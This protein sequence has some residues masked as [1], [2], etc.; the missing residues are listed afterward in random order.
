[1]P[2]VTKSE[3]RDLIYKGLAGMLVTHGFRLNRRQEGFVRRIPDGT[4]CIGVALAD[5]NP[6]YV[7]SL[8]L[9][10]RLESVQS[11]LN[12][13]SGSPQRYHASTVTAITQLEYF[14]KKPRTE[15]AVRTAAD[16]SNAILDL[17]PMVK[18]KIIPFLDRHQD[19]VAWDKAINSTSNDVYGGG[20]LSDRRNSVDNSNHPYRGMTAIAL[21]HLAGNPDF[22]E[23]VR[24]LRD[25]YKGSGEATEKLTRLVDYLTQR[26]M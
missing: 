13:F 16:I 2:P 5:Y 17:E 14:S 1:M 19:V 8:S 4:Q 24:R 18:E 9:S 7:F 25:F 22:D 26:T 6:A 21:A 10:T 15:Y 3:V 11:I 23:I 12:L 20:T